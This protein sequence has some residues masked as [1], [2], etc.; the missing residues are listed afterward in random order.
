M[1]PI[2]ISGMR[3]SLLISRSDEKMHSP[4]NPY[5]KVV[6][7]VIVTAVCVANKVPISLAGTC[8]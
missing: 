1:S 6:I 5:L 2:D 8:M 3:P 7:G 4:R